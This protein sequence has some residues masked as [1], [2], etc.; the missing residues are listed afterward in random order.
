MP[1]GKGDQSLLEAAAERNP[2][3][4]E[5]DELRAFMLRTADTE[6]LAPVFDKCAFDVLLGP[7]D[8]ELCDYATTARYPC[9]TMPLGQLN[10]RGRPFGLIA[11]ARPGREMDLIRVM[12]AWEK[13]FPVR[14]VPDM[15]ALPV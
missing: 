10:D 2:T 4:E 8:S 5:A 14:A 9:C 13:T 6:G 15:D 11:I 7:A 1:S 12:S 3:K